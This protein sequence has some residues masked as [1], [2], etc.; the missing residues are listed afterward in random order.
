MVENCGKSLPHKV[1][2][3]LYPEGYTDGRT[4]TRPDEHT[5][6]RTDT[7]GRRDRQANSSIIPVFVLCG[8]NKSHDRIVY[9]RVE[10]LWEKD[11]KRR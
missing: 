9:E 1:S 7:D 8:Y 10:T 4:D 3:I 11:K 5:S 2:S 6:G